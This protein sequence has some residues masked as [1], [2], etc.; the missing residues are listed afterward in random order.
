M[1][2]RGWFKPCLHIDFISS[3]VSSVTEVSFTLIFKFIK[4]EFQ[5]MVQSAS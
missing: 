4:A 1:L 3:L 5:Q 2:V